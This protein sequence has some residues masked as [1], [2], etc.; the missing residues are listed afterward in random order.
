MEAFEIGVTWFR[1]VLWSVYFLVPL[2]VGT[3]LLLT[4]RLKF[5]QTRKLG[6]SINLT[7]GLYDDDDDPGEVTTLRR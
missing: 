2:L 7:R 6:H 3:G 5:I 4:I 1:D